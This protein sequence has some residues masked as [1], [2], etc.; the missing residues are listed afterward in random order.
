MRIF[1]A[2]LTGAAPR[3][4]RGGARPR[5]ARRSARPRAAGPPPPCSSSRSATWSDCR[6][7]LRGRGRMVA[8]P[9]ERRGDSDARLLAD[10][11]GHA[12]A[13]RVDDREAPTAI[14]S[15]TTVGHGSLYF[16]CR[17][18]SA[19]CISAGASACV[20]GPRSSTASSIPSRRT[21]AAACAGAVRSERERARDE[22]PRVAAAPAG[23]G[24]APRAPPRTGTAGTGCRRA[25]ASAGARPVG[26]RR[27]PLACRPG[28]SGS[29]TA[30][31][32][33]RRSGP[34]RAC[35]TRS[36]RRRGR[37]R[38][39]AARAA[40][41]RARSRRRTTRDT[42]RRSG[43]RRRRLRGGGRGAR[44]ARASSGMLL[45]PR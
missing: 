10:E 32:A 12:A 2:A 21:R 13:R 28:C 15:S 18:M 5:P 7:E 17:R 40:G 19:R 31:R 38:A 35:R 26:E 8:L 42:R 14:A 27:E 30:P 36:G 43:S 23:V 24:R 16:V 33:R 22:E 3:R 9:V 39:A 25:G 6:S 41:S 4:R 44:G 29:P 37:P 11:L 1:R 45:E 20:Y 34:R